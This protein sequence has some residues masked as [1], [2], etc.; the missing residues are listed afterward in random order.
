MKRMGEIR[1]KVLLEN[2]RDLILWREKRLPKNKVRRLTIEA[3]ADTGAVMNLL[4]QEI[5]EALGLEKK[6]KTIVTLAD[7]KKVEL[8]IAGN[9]AM[10]VAGR[11]WE[12]DCLVG[13][14]GCAPLIGQ[15]VME[16]L[17]LIADPLKRTLT[18]RPES[19]YLP[20]LNLL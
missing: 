2:E 6:G 11:K 13:P 20:T 4:P 1:A 15:L 10:T 12:T 17:D 14:P 16:R 3:T 8:E 9:V 5:V 7:N 18:P 19:P